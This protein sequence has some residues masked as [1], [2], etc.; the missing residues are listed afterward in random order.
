MGK[1]NDILLAKKGAGRLG[2]N[3]AHPYCKNNEKTCSEGN[4]K[5]VTGLLFKELVLYEQNT[6]S[7]N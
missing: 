7:L 6:F 2:K 3:S 1:R 4:T 5:G